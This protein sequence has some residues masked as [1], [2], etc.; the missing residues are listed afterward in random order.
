MDCTCDIGFYGMWNKKN[1]LAI[2]QR[3]L[4]LTDP[5]RGSDMHDKNLELLIKT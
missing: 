4:L 3:I 1:Q 2:S 5:T